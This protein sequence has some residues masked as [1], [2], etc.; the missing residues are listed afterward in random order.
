L[1]ALTAY[2]NPF[3][4]GKYTTPL[5]IAGVADMSLPAKN[6]HFSRKFLTVN[7]LIST[8]PFALL[9]LLISAP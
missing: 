2:K 9:V 6:V 1:N 5:A 3:Q 4:D 8:S 7:R